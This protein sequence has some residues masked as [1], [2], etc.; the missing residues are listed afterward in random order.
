MPI[1]KKQQAAQEHLLDNNEFWLPDFCSRTFTLRVAV[2]CVLISLFLLLA[3]SPSLWPFPFWDYVLLLLLTSSVMG[4]S[5]FLICRWRQRMMAWRHLAVAAAVVVIIM[6][7]LLWLSLVGFM[8]LDALNLPM[9]SFV[10]NEYSAI[11]RHLL[12]SGLFAGLF[13]RYLTL[14]A[15]LRNREKAAMQARLEALQARIEPHFLFN[16]MNIIASLIS[17]DPEKAE[18]VVEDLAA[19]FRASLKDTADV[20]LADEIALCRRYANIE[21]LRLGDRL[22]ID[23]QVAADANAVRIPLLTLQPLLENAIRH[24]AEMSIVP[25]KIIL[26]V[27]ISPDWVRIR[28]TNPL[29]PSPARPGNQM[30]MRNVRL[31]LQARFGPEA[32][33]E[34][35]PKADLFVTELSYPRR[36]A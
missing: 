4:I 1:L 27:Q 22:N 5:F 31:R 25:C 26:A 13:M 30:S 18:Q 16:S 20:S 11:F 8:L 32:T 12:I 33:L 23:W 35:A 34:A 28:L 36:L 19:L 10:S 21:E 14:Q 24:G 15:Q 29:P 2:I 17:I 7:N 6:F 9:L 3:Q